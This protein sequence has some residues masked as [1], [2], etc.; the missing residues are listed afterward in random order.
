V[1]AAHGEAAGMCRFRS[2]L[3]KSAD[4]GIAESQ[5]WQLERSWKMLY[6]PIPDEEANRILAEVFPD[7]P[8]A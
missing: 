2:G 1:G 7:E 3:S 5:D 8:G 4:R 6:D